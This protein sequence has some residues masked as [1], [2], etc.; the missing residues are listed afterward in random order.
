MARRRNVDLRGEARARVADAHVQAQ[1]DPL[2]D[3]QASVHALRDQSARF[4]A[5]KGGRLTAIDSFTRT[6]SSPPGTRSVP[7]RRAG[8]SGR[9]RASPSS[10]TWKSAVPYRSPS[11]SRPISFAHGEGAGG[12]LGQRLQAALERLEEAA[13]LERA[14]R[15]RPLLGRLG[16]MA[17][18]GRRRRPGRSAPSSAA[19]IRAAA[20]AS[21]LRMLSTI[22]CLRMPTSQVRTDDLPA[23]RD[24]P[25]IAAS[26]RVLHGIFGRAAVAQL[27]E[28]EAQ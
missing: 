11:V 16:E 27:Q 23:K 1:P 6:W 15:A 26:K 2:G 8:S 13:L 24:A 19:R 25:W 22:L 9:D 18:A 7:G 4:L 5:A 12:V 3:G 21:V 28:R 14:V 10:W 20:H 17:V